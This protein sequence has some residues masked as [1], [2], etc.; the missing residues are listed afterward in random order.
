MSSRWIPIAANGQASI[1]T[2]TACSS[3]GASNVTPW[4]A[5]R[6]RPTTSDD[7]PSQMPTR[8]ASSEPSTAPSARPTTT[9]MPPRRSRQNTA[10]A[11]STPKPMASRTNVPSA[12]IASSPSLF[13]RKTAV[14]SETSGTRGASHSHSSPSTRPASATRTTTTAA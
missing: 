2:H 12:P 3:S 6:A 5:S 9:R 11:E 1:A 4:P 10:A 14:S 7:G 13:F 8:H